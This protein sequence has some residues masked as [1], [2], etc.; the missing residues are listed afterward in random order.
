[1]TLRARLP[2]DGRL[3][4]RDG[5]ERLRRAWRLQEYGKVQGIYLP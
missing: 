5:A 2:I 4:A 3:A 1:M